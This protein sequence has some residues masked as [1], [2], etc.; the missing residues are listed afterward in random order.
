MS[1]NGVTSMSP[2]IGDA[3]VV[4]DLVHLAE[5]LLDGVGVEQEGLALGD[6]E[7][8]GLDLDA[9]RL[10]LLLGLGQPVEVD[11]ADRHAWRPSGPARRPAPARYPNPRR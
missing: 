7:T 11:V 10:Q 4:V 2:V 3:G 8:V 9:D 6:V 1:L 5:V